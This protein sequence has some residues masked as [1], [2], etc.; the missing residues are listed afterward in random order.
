MGRKLNMGNRRI[1]A[2]PRQQR[3]MVLL[4]ALI[5]LVAM[6]LAAIGMM[7]SVDTTT[8]IA[9]NVAFKQATLQSADQGIFIP[10]S[11]L[12]NIANVGTDKAVLNSN[13]GSLC[14]AGVSAYLC[15]GGNINFPGYRATP[16]NAC[17]VMNTC[18]GQPWW[19]Q[20]ANW[21]GA[22]SVTVND[23]SGNVL[24]TVSYW[25][26][27]MCTTA[28]LA[29]NDPNNLCQTYQ[30]TGASAP[31]SHAVGS[32]VFTNMSVFYRITS[33]SVGPRNTVAYSQSLVL[34]PE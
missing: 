20:S 3:G 33:K 5:V 19:T 16:P 31:G 11:T 18:L 9:G 7:R 12:L 26:H 6:T 23:A 4:I 24:A 28:D 10:Y 14:P 21:T 13:H 27:R 25:V 15:A 34:L 17:E 30:E 29:S 8:V 1:V 22:P 2:P 32:F